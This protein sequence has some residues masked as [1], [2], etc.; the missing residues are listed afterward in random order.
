[1]VKE[2]KMNDHFRRA[3]E[4]IFCRLIVIYKGEKTIIEELDHLLF[5]SHCRQNIKLKVLRRL[6][7]EAD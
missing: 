3:A 2:W 4:T 7:I 5:Y 1:M 6:A